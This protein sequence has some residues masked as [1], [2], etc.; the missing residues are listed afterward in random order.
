MT[1]ELTINGT[2][3]RSRA[4]VGTTLLDVLRDELQL[5]GTKKGCVEGECGAC[6]VLVDGAPVD[7]CLLAVHSLAGREVTTIEGIGSDDSLSTLQQAIVDAGGVQCG[8]CTPGIVMTLHALLQRSPHPT[9]AEVR[10]ALA[11][12]I[13]RCTGYAQI[14]AA[15]LRVTSETGHDQHDGDTGEGVV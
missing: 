4:D 13:C 2:P 15:V 3:Q 8:F 7:S 11:G 5:T 10:H 1:V 12:N 6:T 14:V 9:A